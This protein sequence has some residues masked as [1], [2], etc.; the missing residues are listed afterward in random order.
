MRVFSLAILTSH[1]TQFDD[2]LFRRMADSGSFDLTVY[3]LDSDDISQEID[4]ELGFSP[5][6]DLPLL[7]GYR[8]I[9]CPRG[10]LARVR[11]LA[12][13]C[14]L[15]PHYDLVIVPGYARA[16]LAL[17]AH[18]YGKQPLGMRLDNAPIHAEPRWKTLL[19]K[20]ILKLVLPRY[21]VFHPVGSLSNSF[22]WEL[23]VSPARTFRFPYAVDNDFFRVRAERFRKERDPLLAELGIRTDSFIVLGVLKFVRRENP[24]EL[25]SGFDLL[26][27]K[28]PNSALILVG[29]GPLEQESRDYMERAKLSE[30][31][32]LPGY[33]KYSELPKWYG[34]SNVFVHPATREPWGVSINEAMASG[35][36]IVGSNRVGATY[37]LVTP[38]VNGFRYRGGD[39]RGMADRLAEI[40][41]RPD[42]GGEMGRASQHI[43]RDWSLEAS[44]ASLRDA[45]LEVRGVREASTSTEATE[46]PK[47]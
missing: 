35:L 27:Q 38:G 19:R 44:I 40:A 22:L 23:G 46:V 43:I 2:P 14:F 34:I 1:P 32:C 39:V 47:L 26:H 45:L 41:S 31:V 21:A 37:D 13:E 10:F 18:L 4:P 3:F 9:A 11:F 36:P 16:D 30:A 24:I 15:K 28:F 12:R 20:R 42:Q 5:N 8:S 33:A 25:L 17:L 29:A 6:W 7:S